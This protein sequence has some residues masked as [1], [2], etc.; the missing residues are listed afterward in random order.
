MLRTSRMIHPLC[1]FSAH[2]ISHVLTRTILGDCALLPVMPFIKLDANQT[3]TCHKVPSLLLGEKNEDKRQS[4][5]EPADYCFHII[6]QASCLKLITPCIYIRWI[7]SAFSHQHEHG[8]PAVRL[9]QLNVRPDQPAK[10]S[11]KAA[12]FSCLKVRADGNE[13]V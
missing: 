6:S 7:H 10:L 12:I 5:F 4:K 13:W 8:L 9:C 3:L 11:N 2:T 1:W